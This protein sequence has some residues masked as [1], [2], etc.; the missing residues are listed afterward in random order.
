MG[1]VENLRKLFAHDRW[2]NE[3]VLHA[4]RECGADCGNSLELLAHIVAAERLWYERVAG[5]PQSM[6]VWPKAGLQEIERAMK[7]TADLWRQYLAE[8]SDADLDG[9][10]E[11]RNTK[12]EKYNSRIEDI[13]LHVMLH[14]AHHRGQI[15]LRMRAAG[16]TPAYVDYIH[17]VRQG[18]LG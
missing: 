6:P 12:G 15:A 16:A 5:V 9:T 13:A 17:A 4:M 14:S 18:L 2:A 1:T 7:E 11:Y 3:E 10:A 8:A